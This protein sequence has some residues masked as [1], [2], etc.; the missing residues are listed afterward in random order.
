MQNEVTPINF[1]PLT[2]HGPAPAPA[3]NPAPAPPYSPSSPPQPALPAL[4]APGQEPMDKIHTS[5]KY[6]TS[7]CPLTGI[8]FDKI[9]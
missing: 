7:W 6:S 2:G 1:A 4:L 8:L 3:P 5:I 9:L